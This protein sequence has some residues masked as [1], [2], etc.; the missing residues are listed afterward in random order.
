VTARRD[1]WKRNKVAGLSGTI[2]ILQKAIDE[3]DGYL[4]AR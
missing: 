3:L 4:L 1:A 2:E